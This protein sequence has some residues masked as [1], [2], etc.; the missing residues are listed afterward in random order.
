MR[1]PFLPLNHGKDIV[2]LPFGEVGNALQYVGK[3]R[4]CTNQAEDVSVMSLP[5]FGTFAFSSNGIDGDVLIRFSGGIKKWHD[6]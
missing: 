4:L 3:R 6:G 1:L 2:A 5:L